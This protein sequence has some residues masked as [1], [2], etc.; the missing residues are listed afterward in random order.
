M[1]SLQIVTREFDTLKQSRDKGI[2]VVESGL[3]ELN[4]MCSTFCS[5]MLPLFVKKDTAEERLILDLQSIIQDGTAFEK[6]QSGMSA[7]EDFMKKVDAGATQILRTI[8]L[9]KDIRENYKTILRVRDNAQHLQQVLEVA[10]KTLEIVEAERKK[11]IEDSLDAVSADVA[12]MYKKLH[13]G[14]EL[15]DIKLFLNPNRKNSLEMTGSFYGEK[16]ISMQSLYSESHLD[17]MGI[18]I[19]IALAKKYSE[20]NI[21][22][23]MDDV[24]MS[25]DDKH[26]D[27]FIELL[28]S[29]A[30]KFSQ[31]ILTTHYRPWRDRYRTHRAPGG[32]FT[33]LNCEI[34][35]GKQGYSYRMAGSKCANW[36]WLCLTNP[37]LTGK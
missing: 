16:E 3:T 2:A 20:P 7:L 14:E 6:L 22:L 19:F 36:N 12:S 26:L 1:K 23:L 10:E 24:I 31:I 35:P 18:C 27:R 34:G 25:I 9:V 28:H 33:L 30:D 8:Q 13:P 11:F 29:E 4:E 5:V 32:R 15:G 17:T 21:I 37:T